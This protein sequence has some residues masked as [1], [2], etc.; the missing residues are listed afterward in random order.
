MRWL[1]T[2]IGGT[3]LVGGALSWALTA[4]AMSAVHAAEARALGP[5]HT[6]E[7][8][9]E[10]ELALV[11]HDVRLAAMAAMWCA[12]PLLPAHRAGW[13]GTRPAPVAS[14]LGAGAA[15][16]VANATLGRAVDGRSPALAAVLVLAAVAAGAAV[17]AL[18]ARGR[19]AGRPAAPT[20]AGVR[21]WWLAGSG[22]LAAGTAAAASVQGL[23]SERYA[24]FTP[25]EL[26]TANALVTLTLLL[27]SG[28]CAAAL[29]P[30]TG[31]GRTPS[32]RTPGAL[33]RAAPVVAPT[34]LAAVLLLNPG[35]VV[36]GARDLPWA[37][38]PAL[39]AALAPFLLA[40]GPGLRAPSRRRVLTTALVLTGLGVVST[41]ALPV[42][43]PVI[44]V[45]GVLGL[46]LTAPAGAYV[47]YDG[48]PMTGAG[49]LLAL[50]ALTVL[51]VLT[52]EREARRAPATER[53]PA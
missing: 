19:R 16:V 48:L 41:V 37:V 45:G 52:G 49:G 34:A 25:Q 51:L 8:P 42:L 2:A 30:A 4:T 38:G 12:L 39:V 32:A 18:L 20:A 10:D 6:P 47:N 9:G 53:S 44:V 46:T 28:A 50:G 3:A 33:V 13:R 1:G 43:A 26:A 27:V 14:W 40:A 29:R 11:A 31:A 15:L 24:A 35:G 17:G 22:T 7:M 23:G 21:W 5:G 36:P